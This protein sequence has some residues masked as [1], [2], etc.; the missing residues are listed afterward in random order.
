MISLLLS[1]LML[2]KATYYHPSLHGGVTRSGEVYNRWSPDT[3]AVADIGGVPLLA[4][5]TW[6]EVCNE[7]TCIEVQVRDTGYFRWNNLDLSEGAFTRLAPRS[8]GR[9]NITWRVINGE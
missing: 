2:G 7:D 8:R 6:L 9:I 4:M 1:L 3:V 5:G